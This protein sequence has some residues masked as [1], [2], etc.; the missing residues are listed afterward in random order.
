MVINR[1]TGMCR[2]TS[3]FIIFLFL[4]SAL[5]STVTAAAEPV[6]AQVKIEIKQ[7][8]TLERQAFDAMM[9]INNGLDTL[10]IDDVDVSVSFQDEIGTNVLATTDPND[11]DPDVQILYPNRLDG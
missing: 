4:E 10:S 8:L 7:E 11:P 3:L 2:V 9:R 1:A 6:C 5:F